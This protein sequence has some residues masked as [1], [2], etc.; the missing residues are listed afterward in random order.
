[1]IWNRTSKVACV[2]AFIGAA[3]AGSLALGAP[4]AANVQVI[5]EDGM[6]TALKSMPRAVEQGEPWIRPTFYQPVTLDRD[7]LR[8]TLA[9]APM[10]F[11]ERALNHPLRIELPTPDGAFAEFDIV[12]SPVMAPELAAKF[13]E[14][15]T[16]SGQGVTDPAAAV[17]LDWTP[18]GFHAQV[19]SP[20]GSYYI[21][22]YT[23][24][25]TATYASYFR[26]DIA[27]LAHDWAC[28]V[29]GDIGLDDQPRLQRR[30][31]DPQVTANRSGTFLQTY[32]TAVAATG[33]YTTFHGGTQALGQAAIVTAINRVTGVYEIELSVRLQ[34]V[35]NNNTLVF[36]NSATDPYTNN[37]G[38]TMLGQNQTTIDATIGTAN[39]DIGHVFST[40]GGGIAGLRVVCVGGQKSRGVTGLP[41]PTGDAFYIDFVAHEM[42]H[43]FG[44]NHCFNST[45]ASCG[46]GNRNAST[47][48][49]PGSGA[50]IMAYAGICGADNLQPNSDAY[51]HSV[52]FDEI[53]AFTTGATGGCPT[54]VSN[55]NTVPTVSAGPNFTIPIGTPFTLTP[56]SS[57]DINGD[58]LTYNWEQRNLGISQNSVSGAILDN[59]QSPFIRS[60]TPTTNPSRTIPRLANLLNNTFAFGERLPATSRTMTFRCT[61][62]DNRAGG[63]GVN[64]S[65][66]AVISTTSA[67]PFLVT[68]PNSFVTWS[69]NQTVT[70]N[71]ANTNL[72]PVSTANVKIELSTDG[73][74]TF[75][76]VLLASTP[77]D[78]S[79]GVT[80]PSLST[81]TARIRVSAVGNIYFDISNANFTITPAPVPG[82]FSLTSPTQTQAN[83]SLEPTIAWTASNNATSYTLTVDTDTLFTPPFAYQNTTALLSDTLPTG[84]LTNSTLYFWRVEATN[85]FGSV[86]GSPNPNDFVTLAPPPFCMGDANGDGQVNFADITA[87]LSNW[88]V[89]SAPG[90]ASPG[91]ANNNG[92]VN[93]EDITTV[94][95]NWAVTCP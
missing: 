74:N 44:G 24:G 88:G 83:V 34:L 64:T 42:G 49:E 51:M 61:V 11:T 93:F 18:Q 85:G 22:P 25:D 67:G 65:D 92:V 9:D 56:A 89:G 94:L 6:W 4:P 45:T 23:K 3:C 91:D 29:L 12:E 14:I 52:S 7:V 47:A 90:S 72:A 80:L 81:S 1:M 21:D 59:G 26:R 27:P 15:K 19:L 77:N 62:R 78:G 70:W 13:P 76:T 57:G 40:G 71:V 54:N 63:G 87:I 55:G 86:F 53:L 48:Y 20:E 36:T 16:Y 28:G 75:P 8:L 39:Y 31:G 46:G 32:R 69:A 68:S 58:T 17:R 41:S 37:N 66:M 84:T 35:A 82:P 50:T 79:E 38:G 10:E 43:Q 2:L 95:S 33:E 30:A 5:S 73:G 60:W